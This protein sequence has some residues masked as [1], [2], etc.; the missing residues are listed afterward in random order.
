MSL[1]N[2]FRW[3]GPDGQPYVTKTV[4]IVEILK[5]MN[6][7]LNGG[8]QE[9]YALPTKKEFVG[10]HLFMYTMNLPTGMDINDRMTLKMTIRMTVLHTL[11]DS[12]RVLMLLTKL[13]QR[14]VN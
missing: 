10:E 12:V 5:T 2:G 11:H 8:D 6:R 1:E 14:A 7:T 4:S 9:Y 13:K 3:E